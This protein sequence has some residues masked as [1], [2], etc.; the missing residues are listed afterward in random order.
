MQVRLVPPAIPVTH[1]TQATYIGTTQPHNMD[2]AV[3]V[4]SQGIKVGSDNE[5]MASQTMGA[6]RYKCILLLIGND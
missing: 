1:K 5:L 6:R 4:C 3:Y 2:R